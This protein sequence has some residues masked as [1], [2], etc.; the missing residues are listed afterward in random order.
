MGSTSARIRP[1]DVAPLRLVPTPS[2]DDPRPGVVA[3]ILAD[4]SIR[5]LAG[6][7]LE[8]HEPTSTW[9]SGSLAGEGWILWWERRYF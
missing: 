6:R 9:A 1:T 5:E 7:P 8:Q 2:A 4:G 3:V